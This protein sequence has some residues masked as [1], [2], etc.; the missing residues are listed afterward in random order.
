MEILTKAFV[1][2]AREIP[3]REYIAIMATT[4]LELVAEIPTIR[5]MP[6]YQVAMR[7]RTATAMLAPNELV[8]AFRETNRPP[9]GDP[10]GVSMTE[11]QV[12]DRILEISAR[13]HRLPHEP[14]YVPIR[15]RPPWCYDDADALDLGPSE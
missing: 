11:R 2:L 10:R 5:L 8:L 9:A 4:W 15:T 1:A 6:S 7:N 14:R 3:T 12:N 13:A